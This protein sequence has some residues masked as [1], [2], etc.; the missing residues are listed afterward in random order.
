MTGLVIDEAQSL[1]D[2]LLEEVRLL[3]NIETASTKLLNIVLAGQP[4]LLQRLQEPSLHALKQRIALRCELKAFDLPE[5]AAYIAGRLRIAG[6]SPQ[7]IFTH[8][9]VVAIYD[10]TGVLRGTD[11][12]RTPM[13]AN[14][15]GHWLLGLPAG[16]AL[17]FWRDRG[18]MGL[19]AGLS[20][21]LI[22][23]ALALTLG[24]GALTQNRIMWLALLIAA[25]GLLACRF[26]WREAT[27][28]GFRG[29]GLALI[30][31][32]G[33]LSVTRTEHGTEVTLRRRLRD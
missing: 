13:V 33:E 12:T 10:A 31:A 29:R 28:S 22:T 8:E 24:A 27:G 1:P 20:I 19:W 18:V 11:D 16:A 7:D 3:G 17:C 14:L 30:Q 4:E 21:G 23:V 9:A 2:E 6:G 26:R 15:I 5:T 32:L 25:L